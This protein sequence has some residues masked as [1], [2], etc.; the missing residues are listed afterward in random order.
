MVL[1]RNKVLESQY[2]SGRAQDLTPEYPCL[3]TGSIAPSLVSPLQIGDVKI[4]SKFSQAKWGSSV[5]NFK[6]LIRLQRA[7]RLIV[8][9]PDIPSEEMPG[10]WDCPSMDSLRWK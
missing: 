6:I 2:K 4:L 9:S 10:F 5:A 7:N 1:P 3:T 8:D